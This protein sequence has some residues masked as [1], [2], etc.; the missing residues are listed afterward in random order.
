MYFVHQSKV[1]EQFRFGWNFPTFGGYYGPRSQNNKFVIIP[2][3]G[4]SG[5]AENVSFEL[6]CIKIDGVV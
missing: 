6:S 5:L 1:V 3:E 2:L 4:T